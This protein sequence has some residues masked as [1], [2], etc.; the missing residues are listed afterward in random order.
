MMDNLALQIEI[1]NSIED[2]HDKG[3]FI[4]KI[5][6]YYQR[7]SYDSPNKQQCFAYWM[8]ALNRYYDIMFKYF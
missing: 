1:Y 5:V 4:E 6:A 3:L 2:Y 7:S 8:D